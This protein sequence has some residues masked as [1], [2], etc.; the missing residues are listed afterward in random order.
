MEPN[1]ESIEDYDPSIRAEWLALAKKRM[2]QLKTGEVVGIPADEAFR[3]LMDVLRS[4]DRHG[5]GGLSAR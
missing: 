3:S 5:R 2:E 4:A 1:Q